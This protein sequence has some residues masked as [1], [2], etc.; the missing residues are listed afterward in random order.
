MTGVYLRTLLIMHAINIFLNWVLIFGNLGAPAL[1]VTGAGL[2]TTI[3]LFIGTGIYF[4]FALRN[5]RDKG[6]LHRI[7]SFDTLRQQFILSLPASLQQMFFAAGMVTLM[8]ILGRI[9]TAEVAAANVLMTFHITALLPSFGIALAAATLV[10]NALGRKDVKD[11]ARWGW[12]ATVICLIYGVVLGLII[13]PLARP[14]LSFFLTNPDTVELAHLP[15]VLWAVVIGLD[16]AAMVL[17]NALNGAGDTRRSMWIS[18]ISQWAFF[19]P[20][21]WLTGAVLGWGL[22]GVWLVQSIYRGGQALVLAQQWA[23]RR[24]AHVDI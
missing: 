23:S 11:A 7:P 4:F 18:L 6:F 15:L 1:G 24:W 8:W 20:L 3:S 2:A 21:A 22:V 13:I 19:L 10:G 12:D 17:M 16:T 5:A 9:G 14:L